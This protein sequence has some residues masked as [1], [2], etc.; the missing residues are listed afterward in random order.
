M[1][2]SRRLL[3]PGQLRE[4]RRGGIRQRQMGWAVVHIM[5]TSGEPY[6]GGGLSLGLHC[7][8]AM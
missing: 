3:G 4:G 7:S 6:L 8:I 5:L 2:T 1:A